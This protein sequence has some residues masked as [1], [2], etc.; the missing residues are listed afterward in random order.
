MANK[1]EL[2][3]LF[4]VYIQYIMFNF[5]QH[6]YL[7]PKLGFVV[8]NFCYHTNYT[9]AD[10]CVFYV[11]NDINVCDSIYDISKQEYYSIAR[12]Y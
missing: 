1:A 3:F 8:Y 9:K 10:C 12:H 11:F 5:C 4:I 7:L 6:K 2:T